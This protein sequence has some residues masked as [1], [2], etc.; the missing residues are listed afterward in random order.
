MP[1]EAAANASAT[2]MPH[3]QIEIHV[4]RSSSPPSAKSKAKGHLLPGFLL[5]RDRNTGRF[6]SEGLLLRRL[7][8]RSLQ[9]YASAN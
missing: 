3:L 7:H 1:I 5:R 2:C 8:A 9:R 4:L 6:F